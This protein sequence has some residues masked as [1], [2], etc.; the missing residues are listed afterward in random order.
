M[1]REPL[2]PADPDRIRVGRV[3]VDAIGEEA[4][5][6]AVAESV[7]RRDRIAIAYLNAHLV[8]LADRDES[9]ADILDR[10]TYRMPDGVGV[11]LASRLF[12][13]TGL[14]RRLTGTDFYPKLLARADEE[15]WSVFFL[16]DTEETLAALRPLL[17]TRYPRIRGA[18]FRSGFAR[19]DEETLRRI[20]E[21]APDILLIGM[22]APLQERWTMAHRDALACP[23]MITVGGG[24]SFLAGT[25]RRA[26]RWMRVA[27]LE[28]LHR[29]WREPRRL[30]RRYILGIPLF[31]A[32]LLFRRTKG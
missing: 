19:D 23:V 3:R 24:L 14:P 1:S 17:A 9:F 27:G 12:H 30:W 15:G 2:Q 21:A 25:K 18:G 11:Y 5:L 8:T 20:G 10:F 28:W 31:L 22:G 7:R 13:R 26:P 6:D 4:L 16:G 32:A 29:L